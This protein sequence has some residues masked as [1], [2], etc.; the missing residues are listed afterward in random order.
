M[1][2]RDTPSPSHDVRAAAKVQMLV[3]HY[4]GMES[5]EVA[6]ARLC[7]PASQVSAHYLVDEDGTIFRMVPED[8]RAWH[9]G[10]ASWKGVADVNSLSIGIELVNPGHEF[11]YR[12][13]A[14]DQMEAL[15]ELTAELVLRHPIRPEYVL[16]HSDVAPQ[17]KKD[18]GERFDWSRLAAVGVGLY[19]FNK[20][21]LGMASGPVLRQGSES[22][23]VAAVQELFARFG[24]A[25]PR[26]GV[27]DEETVNV[28]YA[29]QRHFRPVVVNGQ[30]DSETTGRLIELVQASGAA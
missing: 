24:Y 20:P 27:F 28:V 13:F 18:P 2:V 25:V 3:L 10:E 14:D 19:P 15:V 21:A 30:L 5:A 1:I 6:L 8:R 22:K 26:S 11:G 7:D 29:F 4:T 9:A 23:E 17:R 12:D 16:G